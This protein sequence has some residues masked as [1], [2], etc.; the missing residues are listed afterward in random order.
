METR[1]YESMYRSEL[2][3]WWFRGKRAV[4]KHLLQLDLDPQKKLLDF[5]CGTGALLSEFRSQVDAYGVDVAPTAIAFCKARG[6]KNVSLCPARDLPSDT[7][8]IIIA[9]DVLEHVDDD[10]AVLK[11]LFRALKKNGRLLVTVPA[12]RF[13]WS[14][15]DEA[16][17]HKRRYSKSELLAVAEAIGRHWQFISYYNMWLFLPVL[18]VRSAKKVFRFGHSAADTNQQPPDF[19]NEALFQ[20]FQSE[21]YL[22]R[23]GTLPFGVSLIAISEKND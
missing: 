9:S 21:K 16:L 7:Y 1:E 14:V 17:H 5:G 10:R 8:D 13:L 23:R 11:D 15:H 19:L 3:H 2:S 4:I 22:L 20:I 6:L 12:H 18:L